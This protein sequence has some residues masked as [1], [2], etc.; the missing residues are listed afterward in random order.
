LPDQLE[1]YAR[2]EGCSVDEARLLLAANLHECVDFSF[3]LLK[4][5]FEG[6]TKHPLLDPYFGQP[7]DHHED[8]SV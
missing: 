1:D 3:R 4:A 5:E 8:S 7:S 6:E 2:R